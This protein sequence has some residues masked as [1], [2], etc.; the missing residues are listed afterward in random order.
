MFVVTY[1]DGA[2]R[3]DLSGHTQYSDA[4]RALVEYEEK[5]YL[6]L[7]IAEKDALSPAP[8]DKAAL[9]AA[10]EAERDQDI[11]D[12]DDK[13]S[14]TDIMSL[15]IPKVDAKIDAIANLTDAKQFLKIFARY[16]LYRFSRI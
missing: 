16:I 12:S 13:F 14:K 3:K 5:G 9:E 6:G 7:L 1:L 8:I 10:R 11:V 15:S 4:Q 2:I